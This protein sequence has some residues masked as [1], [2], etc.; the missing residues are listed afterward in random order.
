ME[1][2][3]REDVASMEPLLLREDALGRGELV[4]SALDLAAK[5]A[6]LHSA[7]PPGVA[8]AIAEVVRS[9]N[10]YYSNLIEGHDTHPI[11]IERALS[12]DYSADARRRNLQLEA[13]AHIE[14]QAWLD[15]G[16]MDVRATTREGL[17]EIHRRFCGRMPRELLVATDPQ[18]DEQVAV[19]PGE[20]RQRDVIVGRHVAVSPGAVPRFLER[21]EAVHA[22]LGRMERILAAATAHHRLLWIHPFLDGNGRVARLMSHAMLS[23]ALGAGGLWSVCRGLARREAEYK[24]LLGNCDLPRRHDTD[25]RGNLSEEALIA[26]CRFFLATCIDQ[27]EFM[28]RLIDPQGLR[29]RIVAWTQVEIA[30]SRLP[31]RSDR[32]FDALLLQGELPRGSVATL[33]GTGSRQARRLTAALMARGT[34]TA[35]STRAPLRLAVPAALLEQWLPNAFPRI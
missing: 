19:V 10:C 24:G 9:M 29:E 17:T 35:R 2:D 26:F 30:A 22:R 4:D 28:T 13:R 3:R 1:N 15:R 16:G 21:F 14:V 8:D 32:I 33:L 11:D 5:S 25:G 6:A 7:L 12:E 20:L 18:S 34:I 31:P 23:E 27:V